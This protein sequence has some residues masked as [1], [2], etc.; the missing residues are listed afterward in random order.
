MVIGDRLQ[1][2]GIL[3][4]DCEA[5]ADYYVRTQGYKRKAKFESGGSQVVFV[6]SPCNVMLE[7]IERPQD[8]EEAN[9]VQ[10]NGGRID[11][12][13]FECDNL[14]AAFTEAKA[15]QLDILEGIVDI[16]EF[17]EH[18]F[19]YFLTRSCGKEKI[20]FCKVN[21]YQKEA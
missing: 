20:E 21:P 12:L 15:Q 13:A 1:H 8:S 16:P 19:R 6:V 11:H 14:E 7:L 18:G 4:P 2:V 3:V 17:W 10:R 9:D 5:A